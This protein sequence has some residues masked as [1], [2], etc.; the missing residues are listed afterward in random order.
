MTVYWEA[1][2]NVTSSDITP[3][4]GSVELPHWDGAV[5][6]Y[7]RYNLTFTLLSDTQAEDT[8]EFCIRLTSATPPT[9]IDPMADTVYITIKANDYPH[10]LFSIDPASVNISLNQ[11]TLSRYLNFSMVRDQ[12]LTSDATLTYSLTYT[13]YGQSE[14]IS[15]VYNN[16]LVVPD[17]VSGLDAS[18]YIGVDTFL[19][20]NGIL[21]L[22]LTDVTAVG[23]A[24]TGLPPRILENSQVIFTVLEYQANA[25]YVI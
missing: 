18:V 20:T 15:L 10:G 7:P 16:T 9:Q 12:G 8:Q 6:A 5:D 23:T 24:D 21:T 3:L 1:T 11:D 13:D 17:G 25:R 22:T 2:C 19:G 4:S 14:S